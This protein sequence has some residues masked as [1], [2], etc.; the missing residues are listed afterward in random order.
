MTPHLCVTECAK[1][2][3]SYAGLQNGEEC[4]CGNNYSTSHRYPR[5]YDSECNV[6]CGGSPLQNCGGYNKNFVYDTSIRML[7]IPK[8][9]LRRYKFLPLAF[10][11]DEQHGYNP[12]DGIHHAH[13]SWGSFTLTYLVR[14]PLDTN[15]VSCKKGKLVVTK[16]LQVSPGKK[17]VL[18]SIFY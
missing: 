18:P 9:F 11:E 1:L 13:S 14:R 17:I 10:Q 7:R 6:K 2:S 16:D 4:R 5:L 8:C 15:I 12:L 3:F